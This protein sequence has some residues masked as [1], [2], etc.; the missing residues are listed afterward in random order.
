MVAKI[1]SQSRTI[2]AKARP[3]Q[4]RPKKSGV[5]AALSASWTRKIPR[6]RRC[7]A[8][9]PRRE[10]PS[11]AGDQLIAIA[12]RTDHNGLH[13]TVVAEAVGQFGQVGVV[14]DASRLPRIRIDEPL[15]DFAGGQGRRGLL[16]L[17]R[18]VEDQPG[19]AGAELGPGGHGRVAVGR[20][21]GPRGRIDSGAA[22]QGLESTAQAS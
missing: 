14:D 19:G 4:C 2:S 17:L 3:G 15:R 20:R 9:P 8:Q 11:L 16:E 10:E 1:V 12:L 13:Q 7:A 22:Q 6:T 5:H 18:L 21:C